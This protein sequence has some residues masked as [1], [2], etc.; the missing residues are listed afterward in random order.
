LFDT[1]ALTAGTL[2]GPYEILAP[3]GEGGM[4]E[5]WKATDTRLGRVVAIKVLKGAH[6][7]RFEQEARAIATLNHPNI[8]TLYDVGPDYLVMEYIEGS[9]LKGPLPVDEAVRLAV[10]IA[11]ALEAAHAKGI[12]H[13]DLKP[14]NVLVNAAGAKL[15][16]FGLAKLTADADT[17]QTVGISGTP[18]YMSPEQAEGKVLDVRTDVFSF[19]AVLY[20]LLS[21]R[22][23]F[24]SLGAVLRDDPIPPPALK[25]VVLR[26]LEKQ[27]AR[28]FQTMAELREALLQA[29]AKPVEKQPSIAVLPF[30]NMSAD[31]EQEYFSDGLAE[32]I[33]N[34]LA[35]TPGLKV[36]ARTSAFAFRGKEQ[37]IQKIAE[38]LHVRTILE[39]SVR[40]SGNRIRVMAQLINAEDGYHLW[41]QRYDREMADL[42]DLQ[43]EIAQSIAAAL[44]VELSGSPAPV[45]NYKP[46]LPAYEALLKARYYSGKFNPGL[47]PR[48]QECFEQAIALDPKFALAHCEYA[49]SFVTR[50]IVG[51]LP[52]SQLVPILRSHAQK[53]L[54]LDPSL[55]EGH[56]LL[57]VVAGY[58]EHDWKEAERRFR[59]ALA[60]DPVPP[61]VSRLYTAYYLLPIGR[62]AEA[63]EQVERALQEDPLDS[64][65]RVYRGASL[66]ALGHD[67]DAI[68]EFH[69]ILELNPNVVPAHAYLGIHHMERGELDQ[70]LM[71]AEK[72]YIL[73][74]LVPHSIGEFAGLLKRVGELQRANELFEKLQRADTFGAA[75]GLATYYL[76]L[77]EFDAAADWIE[78][79]IDQ[80]DPV[81]LT[82]L[83][84]RRMGLFSTPQWARLMRKLNLPEGA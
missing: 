74:P 15:L 68:K 33:I 21:G 19:G 28:R 83:R 17:T 47:F 84:L 26:C 41:S 25:G 2:L 31:K 66:G 70:A 10:Q 52:L 49:V 3:I 60:R 67:E 80:G 12:L 8:C 73:T 29:A 46:S 40:R 14:G 35:Q 5:V 56:A 11:S 78:R 4:G 62:P 75:R 72:A 24:D 16:D 30:A 64:I 6:S 53:A 59:L 61:L 65:L 27:P 71:H 39:G 13:R 48:I 36:T 44:Q 9:P 20:E 69:A 76:M 32:E 42:F 23:A 77:D 37:D 81:A 45:R 34:V 50:A 58:L 82:T 54:E 51:A 7:E 63:L 22:R 1:M 79:A 43:D 55:P 57:G 18:L 38:A